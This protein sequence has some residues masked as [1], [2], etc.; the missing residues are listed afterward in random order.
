MF[1]VNE[2][3]D[4]TQHQ[5]SDG[6]EIAESAQACTSRI[7]L[8]SFPRDGRKPLDLHTGGLTGTHHE[9]EEVHTSQYEKT[10]NVDST[11]S[12]VVAGIGHLKIRQ[13]Y[14]DKVN[15]SDN[16]D[17]NDVGH[18][19]QQKNVSLVFRE[20]E[21]LR[22]FSFVKVNRGLMLSDINNGPSRL[23]FHFGP[24]SSTF[25]LWHT[26]SAMIVF[27]FAMLLTLAPQ[28]ASVP[29]VSCPIETS[30]ID[31]NIYSGSMGC[32]L[33]Y[34]DMHFESDWVTYDQ[35]TGIVTAGDHVHFTRGAEQMDG[36]RLE[37]NARTK[38]GKIWD[39]TGKVDPGFHVKAKVAERFEDQ[40]WEFHN[41]TITACD[42]PKPCWT[43]VLGR[44]WFRPG[45]WVKGKSAVFRFHTV[46]VV[47]L[48]Y[49]AAPSEQKSRSTGFLIPSISK[50]SSKG[51]GFSDEFYYVINDSADASIV[52]EY[53]SIAGPTAEINFRAKP[54]A[55]GWIGVNSFLAKDNDNP[56]K[57]GHIPVGHS[58]RILAYSNLGRYSRGVVDLETESSVQFRQEWGDSFNV[59]ASPINRSVGFLTTNTPNFSS[60]FLY[61]RSE[62][63]HTS[64]SIALRKFPSVEFSIPSHQVLSVIPAYFRLE[65]SVSGVSR[66]DAALINPTFGGRFDVHPVVQMPL[67]RRNAFELSQEFGARETGYTESLLNGVVQHNQFNRFTL[68]YSARFSGPEFDKSYGKWRHSIQPTLD[69]RYVT[70]V[71]H[72][73]DTIIVDDVD[74]VADTSEVEYGITNR[75]IGSRELLSWRVA[76]VAYF[77]PTFG[78]AI[79]P[80]QRNVFNPL[81][82]LTGYSFADGPRH[83][84]P[85]VSTL[86]TEPRPGN[87][88]DL[89]VNYDTQ[90]GEM[91]SAALGAGVRKGM[92]HS[93]MSYVFT[94]TT[95]LQAANNQLH[96]AIS[97][98]NGLNRGFSFSTNV[99][100]DVQQRFFQ[101]ASIQ[102]GYNTECYGLSF[103][104]SQINLGD[105]Q[106]HRVSLAFSLKNIGT[107]GTMR[108]QERAF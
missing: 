89:Q 43:I 53:Y 24:D 86:H 84:S 2:C 94:G 9:E 66:Q 102:L 64:P 70:G 65:G 16:C 88:V 28:Q 25:F 40:S 74:L 60:N 81:L 31:K 103:E 79:R 6:N 80:G 77:N 30:E 54:T 26:Q 12:S 35:S 46:P 33:N 42:A 7:Q 101:G 67:V 90:L 38:A 57:E 50:S 55:S 100:Y 62:F 11:R 96:G 44:A 56:D 22:K 82:S 3:P 37:M 99:S 19:S 83:F 52:G 10:C 105:R 71:D 5:R 91:R 23:S 34:E 18:K 36:T 68:D 14:E 8:S 78:G 48:P 85:I 92:W 17:V 104:F 47:P 39:A 97:Y 29:D 49:F 108:R 76:Q 21:R 15:C 107:F 98:G 45:E 58:L 95:S 41:T 106:E 59:I 73:R 4:K 93:N 87:T 61:S 63:L 1:G 75:I 32:V 51:W 20:S 27:A 13:C 72:F 69:Y